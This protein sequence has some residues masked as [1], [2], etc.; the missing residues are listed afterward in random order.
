MRTVSFV[1]CFELD[2]QGNVFSKAMLVADVDNDN[3]NELVIGNI[4]GDL[5]IYKGYPSDGKPWA[6]AVDLGMISCLEVGDVCNHGM[7]YLVSLSVEGWC[8]MFSI[9]PNTPVPLQADSDNADDVRTL[10][11]TY[12]QRL[13]ANS[14]AI[15]IADIDGDGLNEFVVAH[16]DRVV[17]AYRWT[18][19]DDSSC[20]TSSTIVTNT[21]TT[22]SAGTKNQNGKL[23]LINQWNLLGQIGAM[24]VKQSVSGRLSVLVSQPAGSIVTLIPHPTPSTPQLQLDNQTTTTSHDSNTP[25]ATN[26][27][28]SYH[29]LGSVRAR[30]PHVTTEVVGSISRVKRPTRDSKDCSSVISAPCNYYSAICTLDGTLTLLDEDKILWSLCV[31]HQLFALTKLDVTG[32]GTEEVVACSWDGQTYFVNLSKEIVRFHFRENVAAFCAGMYTVDQSRGNVPCLFYATFNNK[33]FVYNNVRLTQIGTSS[34]LETIQQSTTP[35]TYSAIS[36]GLD[37]SQMRQLY[38]QCLYGYQ[39]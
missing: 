6:K 14:R 24:T 19:V 28:I 10:K 31:D 39:S 8:H 1:D 12:K 21:S 25:T 23:I 26:D 9:R 11:A 29:A 33:I 2:Y 15:V 4:N 38:R 13:A 36:Q 30:N 16:S 22:S 18:C 17:R 34:L 3:N 32:D 5:Y 37:Q 20:A 35:E 7:N 27:Y